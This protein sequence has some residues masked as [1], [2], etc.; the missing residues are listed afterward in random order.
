MLGAR[1]GGCG[2][3]LA[4]LRD[5]FSVV[6][7]RPETFG[8]GVGE[9]TEKVEKVVVQEVV[10]SSGGSGGSGGGIGGG[11]SFMQM[12]ASQKTTGHCWGGEG[13]KMQGG[14]EDRIRQRKGG[15]EGDYGERG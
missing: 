5:A 7:L 10:D 9:Y 14:S 12:V 4:R 3:A 13:G 11:C 2:R 8:G 6:F 15:R 1:R